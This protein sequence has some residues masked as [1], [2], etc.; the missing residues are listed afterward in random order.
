MGVDRAALVKE[1]NYHFK[2]ELNGKFVGAGKVIDAWG[3]SRCYWGTR[4]LKTLSKDITTV[5]PKKG[6]KINFRVK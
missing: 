5:K 4:K 2:L 1:L 6:V 3:L